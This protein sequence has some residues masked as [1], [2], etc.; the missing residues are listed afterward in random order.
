MRSNCQLFADH[1]CFTTRVNR[2]VNDR[3]SVA[4]LVLVLAACDGGSGESGAGSDDESADADTS[5]GPATAPGPTAAATDD[6]TSPTTVD[7]SGDSD[8]G[9][10]GPNFGLLTF[11]LYPA[12]ASGSPEQLG[13]AGAWRTGPSPPTTS[14]PC[15]RSAA[16]SRA[17]PRADDTLEHTGPGVY[18]WGFGDSWVALGN[19]MRLGST[20]SPACRSTR[21]ATRST[22]ATTP[23]TST[24]PARPT[25]PQWQPATAYDLTVYGNDEYPDETRPAVRTPAALT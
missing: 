21:T 3:R 20:P 2:A 12:D 13:M 18:D 8:T 16:S 9:E 7:P 10:V 1:R 22:S 11:T 15:A 5:G 25:P 14:S 24:P 19:G 23:T 4:L 17:P 6:G